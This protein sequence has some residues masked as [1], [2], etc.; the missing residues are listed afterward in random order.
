M[1]AHSCPTERRRRCGHT[2]GLRRGL[3]FVALA[4]RDLP[5][6]SMCLWCEGNTELPLFMQGGK[7]KEK[8]QPDPGMRGRVALSLLP[9]RAG[10][11]RGAGAG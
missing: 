9:L 10:G 2:P 8:T 5:S 6:L 7:Q 1:P 3:G 11:G 4:V